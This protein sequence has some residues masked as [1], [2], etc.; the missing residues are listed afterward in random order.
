MHNGPVNALILTKEEIEGESK[1]KLLISGSEDCK[2]II[3]DLN[4]LRKKKN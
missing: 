3:I 2:L 4:R 1:S